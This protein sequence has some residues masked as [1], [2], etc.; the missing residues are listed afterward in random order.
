MQSSF[1]F[2]IIGNL[3]CHKVTVPSE[4]HS[5]DITT[6][7]DIIWRVCTEPYFIDGVEV[8]AKVLTSRASAN[9]PHVMVQ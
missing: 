7:A 3:R 5:T 9:T 8:K 1:L 4:V 2:S 6:D